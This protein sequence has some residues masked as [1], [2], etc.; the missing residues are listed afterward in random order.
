MKIAF[1]CHDEGHATVLCKS[2]VHLWY[3]LVRRE[4]LVLFR[5]KTYMIEEANPRRDFDD[6]LRRWCWL[7]VENDNYIDSR[8]IGFARKS[9]GART[10]SHCVSS[11]RELPGLG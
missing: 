10:R 11:D 1:C 7:R 6:L 2:V 8:L 3:Y 9:C 5:W 4:T